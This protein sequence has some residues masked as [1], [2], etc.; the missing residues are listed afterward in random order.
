M[1]R[2]ASEPGLIFKLEFLLTMSSFQFHF[3][4][5]SL[6]SPFHVNGHQIGPGRK[7]Y[8]S[9]Y[10]RK[11]TGSFQL[12]TDDFTERVLTLSSMICIDENRLKKLCSC[13]VSVNFFFKIMS[14]FTKINITVH[15]A[16][17]KM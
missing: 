11:R 5:L 15:C 6:N 10:F 14:N 12:T 2:S 4:P 17:L 1:K 8:R 13:S 3:S 9:I 7:F 16:K